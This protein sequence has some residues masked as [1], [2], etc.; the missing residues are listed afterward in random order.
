MG[1]SLT[2]G[3]S[4]TEWASFAL[5][6]LG[7]T[8]LFDVPQGDALGWHLAAPSGPESFRLPRRGRDKLAPGN[9]RGMQRAS[10][11]YLSPERARHGNA[12]PGSPWFRPFRAGTGV[13]AS[14]RGRSPAQTG[15]ARQ[16]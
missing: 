6:G 2:N 10:T 7:H 15:T 4:G 12:P 1:S 8:Y 14:S 13:V 11:P 5:S 16:S 3:I 9:A